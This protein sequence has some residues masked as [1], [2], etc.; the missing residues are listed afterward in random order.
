ML[1]FV[2]QR[3]KV[4]VR[5]LYGCTGRALVPSVRPWPTMRWKRSTWDAPTG[6]GSS[7]TYLQ[8]R[9]TL[10]ATV[11]KLHSSTRGGSHNTLSL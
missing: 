6:D 7:S 5:P 10:S 2:H 1:N 9:H 8:K 3:P 11:L 4:M